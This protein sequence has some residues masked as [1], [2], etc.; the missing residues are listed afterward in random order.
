M[1]F[2]K[3]TTLSF[4]ILFILL[5]I[6]PLSAKAGNWRH[7]DDDFNIKFVNN[8]EESSINVKSFKDGRDIIVTTEG[9][10]LEITTETI[11]GLAGLAGN[12]TRS[13]TV[14]LTTMLWLGLIAVLIAIL[15]FV[16]WLSMLVHS[17]TNPIPNKIIWII[18]NVV[19]GVMGAL[20]YYLAVKQRLKEKTII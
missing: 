15:I 12:V 14:L 10:D 17:I 5:G 3:F 8:G 16:F 9:K 18:V 7:Q 6:S 2:I 4:L 11:S 20:V 19:F 13:G 1:K